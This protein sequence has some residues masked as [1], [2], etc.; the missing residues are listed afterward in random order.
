MQT[1]L[2]E[3]VGRFSPA[4]SSRHGL[5]STYV[6]PNLQHWKYV[7]LRRDSLCTSPQKQY[8]GLFKVLH[9]HHMAFI[10]DRGKKPET[11]A[12]DQCK[13]AH[14]NTD[15]PMQVAQ[16]P[17]KG[18]PPSTPKPPPLHPA[19]TSKSRRFRHLSPPPD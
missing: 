18:C 4:P 9:N 2:C 15:Q 12:V 5:Q 13:L 19:A 11:V 16:L 8:K 3:I 6:L 1:R 7:F 17:R 10:I 14:L